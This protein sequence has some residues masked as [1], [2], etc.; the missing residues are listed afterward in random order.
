MKRD[1]LKTAS[2][3]VLHFGVAFTVAYGLTGSVAIA[4]SIGLLEP[5]ANTI[6]FY[7]HERAWRRVDGKASSRNNATAI[8]CGVLKAG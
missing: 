2:F 5:V 6:A 1:L 3:A 8:C 7:F 4:T